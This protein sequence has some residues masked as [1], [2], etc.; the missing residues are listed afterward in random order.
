MKL[1][2]VLHVPPVHTAR[3]QEHRQFIAQPV[4]TR[5]APVHLAPASVLTVKPVTGAPVE[6]CTHS[7][8]LVLVVCHQRDG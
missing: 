3:V 7:A 8:H 5:L 1:G 6:Q 4:L 2:T